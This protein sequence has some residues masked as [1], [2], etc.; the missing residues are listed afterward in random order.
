MGRKRL[1]NR[2]KPKVANE[3]DGFEIKIDSFGEIKSN[4]KI[5]DLNKFL[6][7]RVDDKKLR[8]RED[9]DEIK[10]QSKGREEN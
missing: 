4:L 2:V 7:T 6:N 8:D 3:L 10:E 1:E 5:D 9:L